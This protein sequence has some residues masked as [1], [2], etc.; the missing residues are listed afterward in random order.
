MYQST[1]HLYRVMERLWTR[2]KEHPEMSTT[3]LQSRLIVQFN[4]RDPEGC[5]TVDGSNGEELKIYFGQ[6]SLKADV[7][8]SMKSS[9][10]HEFWQG[11][12]NVPMAL[13]NGSIVSRGPVH[14]ALALLPAVKPAFQMYPSIV[15]ESDGTAA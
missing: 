4:Y 5:L 13:I 1:Q 14:K 10:A 11:S 15:N 6:H 7:E 8:M 3:L 12:L 2:I 9:T